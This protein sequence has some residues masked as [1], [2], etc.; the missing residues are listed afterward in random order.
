MDVLP[1]LHTV[2]P[3]HV[4]LREM[5]DLPAHAE[6]E[7]LGSNN[8]IGTACLSVRVCML[9]WLRTGGG[10]CSGHVGGGRTV[11]QACET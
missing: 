10:C 4:A 5:A 1:L 6:K 9:W 11:D 2:A 3:V 7:D 8:I